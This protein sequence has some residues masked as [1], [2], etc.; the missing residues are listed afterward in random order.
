MK[1]TLLFGIT[2]MACSSLLITQGCATVKQISQQTSPN[3]AEV[4]LYQYQFEQ[5]KEMADWHVEGLGSSYIAKG[6]LIIEPKYQGYMQQ[7]LQQGKIS[8]NNLRAEYEPYLQQAAKQDLGQAA[9]D[10]IED[11]V[12]K[13]G[14]INVWNTQPLPQNYKISYDF[15]SLSASPLHMLMFSAAAMD[16]NSIAIP[17][18]QRIGLAR[19]LMHG[20]QQYRISYFS[21][22]RGS[23]NLRKAPGRKLVAKGKD[24]AALKPNTKHR[25]TIIKQNGEISYWVDDEK[26]LTYQDETP[27]GGGNWG[28][29]TMVMGK[30]AYDNISVYK[31][32]EKQ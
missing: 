15:T 6:Q 23:A 19:E 32:P 5:P 27:L 20:M 10:Y 28:F 7:L 26:V 13:G 18:E 9:T 1:R 16:S 30:V 3:T 21:G 24:L 12:F 22:S 11:G 25:M 14:H 29:R 17:S 2:T 8:N 4:L 31:L